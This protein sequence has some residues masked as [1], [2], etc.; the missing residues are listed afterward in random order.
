MANVKI[1]SADIFLLDRWQ[2]DPPLPINAQ[3][4]QI[5]AEYVALGVSGREPYEIV[6]KINSSRNKNENC[7]IGFKP[8]WGKIFLRVPQ[9]LEYRH[10]LREYEDESQETLS[11]A[12]E[13]HGL[14]PERAKESGCGPEEDA[15]PWPIFHSNYHML[16][17]MSRIQVV[18]ATTLAS[19]GRHAGKVLIFWFDECGRT[20]RYVREALGEAVEMAPEISN[21]G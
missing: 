17:A 7:W 1:S 3:R 16:L 14:D 4:E 13:D 21:T 8:H 5:F 12:I 6:S 15:N 18:D 11:K 2:E 20:I 10:P 19:E 9:L